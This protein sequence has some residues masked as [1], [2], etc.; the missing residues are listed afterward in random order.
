MRAY[1]F[2]RPPIQGPLH[3][4]RVWA[5]ALIWQH[6]QRS[7]NEFRILTDEVMPV[8]LQNV[9]GEE[10]M[11]IQNHDPRNPRLG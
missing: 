8:E 1:P 5:R 3:G 9:C 2:K 7:A 6:I 11:P 10:H 4:D